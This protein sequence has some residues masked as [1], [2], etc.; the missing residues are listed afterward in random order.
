[1]LVVTKKEINRVSPMVED[2]ERFNLELRF[3]Y[4]AKD[5]KLIFMHVEVSHLK[6]VACKLEYKKMDLQG[7]LSASENLKNELDELQGAHTELVDKNAQLKNEK[8]GH[9]V[10]LPS[11]QAVFY[12][13]GYVDY[14]QGKSSDYEFSENDFKTFS[15]S[16]VD[17]L[18]FSFEAAFSGAT[19]GQAVQVGATNDELL[20]VLAAGNGTIAEGVTVEEPMVTQVAKE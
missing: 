3:A 12:K 10:A 17:L 13:L 8:I 16:A 1:M 4:F 14:V 11:C 6:E 9:E 2:L 5:E 20:E 19:K 18:D 15:I 7:A